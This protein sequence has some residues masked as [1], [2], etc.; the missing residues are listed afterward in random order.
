MT[1][2]DE[3]VAIKV[4][5]AEHG[6]PAGKLADVELHFTAGALDGLRLLGFT[7][8]EGRGGKG[9]TVSLPSRQYVVNGERRSFT[10]LRPTGDTPAA[11]TLRDTLLAVFSNHGPDQAAGA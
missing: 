9:P 10:L 5:P 1:E 11:D 4:L 8:W 2:L 6:A 7:V 3:M